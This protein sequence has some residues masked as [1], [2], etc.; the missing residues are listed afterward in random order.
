MCVLYMKPFIPPVNIQ[1]NQCRY[2]LFYHG[3]LQSSGVTKLLDATETLPYCA[4]SGVDNEMWADGCDSGDQSRR[5]STS[6][7]Q[8]CTLRL[9]IRVHIHCLY[10]DKYTE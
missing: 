1:H 8:R 10:I 3:E 2:R 4:A 6:S 7:G 9:G 5:R